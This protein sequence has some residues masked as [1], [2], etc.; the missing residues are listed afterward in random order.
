[1]RV[2][3]RRGAQAHRGRQRAMGA[4]ARSKVVRYIRNFQGVFRK[5]E[6]ER[7]IMSARP[8]Y[9]AIDDQGRITLTSKV[10]ALIFVIIIPAIATAYALVSGCLQGFRPLDLEI[11][12]GMYVAN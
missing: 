11:F 6:G 7:G 4:S 1:M 10:T 8:K 9:P 2:L 3:F 5:A 12:A